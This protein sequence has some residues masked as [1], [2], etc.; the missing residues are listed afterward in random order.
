MKRVLPV[1]FVISLTLCLAGCDALRKMAGRP[2]SADIAAYR[3]AIASAEAARTKAVAD[4]LAREDSVR[5]AAK[6][7]EEALR[8]ELLEHAPYCIIVGTFQESAN[9]ERLLS[10][11]LQAGYQG[12]L[13]K[14]GNGFT[15]VYIAPSMTLEEVKEAYKSVA[16]EKFCPKGICIRKAK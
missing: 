10:Q 6:E 11:F 1:V 7:A 12:K 9:A 14:Q 2:V 15:A 3:E 13:Q 5:R 4:S 16:A 8:R